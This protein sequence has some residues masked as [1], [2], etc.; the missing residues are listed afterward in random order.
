MK[1]AVEWPSALL[2]WA[3]AESVCQEAMAFLDVALPKRYAR[4]LT[5]KAEI[6]FKRNVRFRKK[7]MGKGNAAR[8]DLRMYMRHW[9][10]SLLHEE[11]PDLWYALPGSFDLGHRLPEGQHPRQ[12]R[13]QHGALPKSRR[14]NPS[15]ALSNTRWQFLEKR[16]AV[17]RKASARSDTPLPYEAVH[18]YPI[19]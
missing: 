9:L 11:R 16:P 15:R 19:C 8:D 12:N 3:V 4:W 18:E 7:M 10:S 14:W 1:T 2:P 17:P 13:R 6:C 5:A